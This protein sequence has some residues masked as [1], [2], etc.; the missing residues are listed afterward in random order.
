MKIIP[1]HALKLGMF[2]SELDRPWLGTPFPLQGLLISAPWQIELLTELCY[3]VK[4]DPRHSQG[5]Y[6]EAFDDGKI[7]GTQRYYASPHTRLNFLEVL[8]RI[9]EDTAERPKYLPRVHPQT[10]CSA[11]E[12][13]ILYSARFIDD[14]RCTLKQVFDSVQ[15]G[16]PLDLTHLTRQVRHVAE[17]I[18]RNSEAILW[19]TY[20]KITDN[21][22]Y[23]HALDVSV[24]LMVFAR[25]LGLPKSEVEQLGVVGLMQDIGKVQLPPE[26]LCKAESLSEEEYRLLQ[27]H[28]DSSLDILARQKELDPFIP[29][30]VARHHERIDGSGYPRRLA[31]EALGLSAEMAGFI[32]TYCAII[33]K[34]PYAI[35]LSTQKAIAEL[36]VMRGNR[37]R[38]TIVDQFI[39][40]MGIYPIGSLVE[41]NTDEVAVVI[42][43]NQVRRLRPRV[44]VIMN[45]DKTI[46]RYPR[47]ID[48]LMEPLSPSGEEPYQIRRALPEDAYGINPRD[49]YLV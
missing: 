39:Q 35:T 44:L 48:L 33:R 20:L 11:L 23:D 10:Q 32:D 47:S 2:V 29:G 14:I 41:L 9:R 49:F 6:Y 17:G 21:Y 12:E 25:F 42:Q 43:Q 18:S 24:R 7:L 27:T 30:I 5:I 3:T 22:S 45:P 8:R 1:V 34:R 4:V 36:V 26:L 15:T 28:V 16:E 31:G 40:C 37:F 38:A 46:E 13:E 19:L